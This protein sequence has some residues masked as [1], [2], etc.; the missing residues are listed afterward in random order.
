MGVCATFNAGTIDDQAGATLGCRLYHGGAPAAA[1]PATHCGHAGPLGE[2]VC[3]DDC[4]N[5]CA[6]ATA[7][8]G[9]QP[10]APYADNAACLTACAGFAD[11]TAVPYNTAA[12]SGDSL[13]CRMYHLSVASSDAASATTHCPHIA[14]VSPVCQ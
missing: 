2:G 1:A 3:G 14:E 7:V 8:C 4:A 13:A 5:F 11:T 6:I 10:T 12:T 9:S